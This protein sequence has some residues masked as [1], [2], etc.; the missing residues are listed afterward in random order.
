MGKPQNHDRGAP[1]VAL[2]KKYGFIL[3]Q[4]GGKITAIFPPF[5][6]GGQGGLC[7]AL[8]IPLNPPLEKGDFHGL[9]IK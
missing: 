3:E 4:N 8:I 2:R 7:K 1:G 9:I 6:K 5:L